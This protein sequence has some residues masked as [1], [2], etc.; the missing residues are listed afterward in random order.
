MYNL[1]S[2][3]RLFGE[4]SG[5]PLRRQP[6][7]CQGYL[8]IPRWPKAADRSR[9]KAPTDVIGWEFGPLGPGQKGLRNIWKTPEIIYTENTTFIGYLLGISLLSPFFGGVTQKYKKTA[10]LPTIFKGITIFPMKS[11]TVGYLWG[12]VVVKG[13]S[14]HQR[15]NLCIA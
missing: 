3:H 9:P 14:L 15:A 2:A 8:P 12:M 1:C 5:V 10:S 13:L 4:T 11:A 7:P 6:V